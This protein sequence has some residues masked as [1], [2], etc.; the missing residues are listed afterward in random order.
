MT[1]KVEILM[2][3]TKQSKY[4]KEETPRENQLTELNSVETKES[5]RTKR[6]GGKVVTDGV[7]D[8]TKRTEETA[9]M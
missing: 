5:D 8:R 4:V 1:D 2:S 6:S 9:S 7:K 3:E